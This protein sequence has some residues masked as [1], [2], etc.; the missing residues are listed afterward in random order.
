MV[1]LEHREEDRQGFGRSDALRIRPEPH[2]PPILPLDW[3]DRAVPETAGLW[4]QN[5]M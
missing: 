3:I 1:G 4:L 5:S 2:R